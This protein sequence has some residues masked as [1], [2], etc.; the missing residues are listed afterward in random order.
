[1]VKDKGFDL[2]IRA[3]AEMA[4]TFPEITLT[5]AGDGR[6]AESLRQ[7][8]RD[9]GFGSRIHFPGY[10]DQE[11]VPALI[12][13]HSALIMP[14]RWAEPF[15]LVALQAAQMGRPIIAAATGALPEIVIHGV[16]GTSVPNEN[17][18]A[19]REALRRFIEN[20]ALLEKMGTQARLHV[21]SYFPYERF[22]ARYE[23]AYLD[24]AKTVSENRTLACRAD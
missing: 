20:P 13:R 12:N 9:T 15:G 6:D 7:L 24:A 5:V 10:V 11:E 16:T 4:K 23:Q 19:Y 18:P 2:A 22:L 1:L 8:A 21:E 3:F 17:I 14:S